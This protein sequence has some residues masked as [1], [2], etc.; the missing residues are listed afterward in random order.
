VVF[1][2]PDLAWSE[3]DW[4]QPGQRA[5]DV[6]GRMTWFPLV[7]LWQTLLDLPAA[8]STPDG[9]GHLYS[10]RANVQS[11]AAVTDAPGWTST[12]TE[13]LTA[14]M[15]ERRAVRKS[16]IDQLGD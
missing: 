13:T 3:P 2:S 14:L 8:E 12:D 16:L 10:I 15:E 1:V 6:S 5:P 9:Y 4:L 7:T 11:W